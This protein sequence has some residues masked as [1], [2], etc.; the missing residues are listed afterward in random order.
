[1]RQGSGN[2]IYTEAEIGM[3]KGRQ[4]IALPQ[5]IKQALC[6]FVS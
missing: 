6:L 4:M 2:A 1:M 5:K 3:L